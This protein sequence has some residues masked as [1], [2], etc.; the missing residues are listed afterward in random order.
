MEGRARTA[1]VVT[2]QSSDPIRLARTFLLVALALCSTAVARAQ[3]PADEP[4]TTREIYVPVSDL[5]VLLESGP[6][7]VLL[8][9][10]EYD[11]LVKKAK[12]TPEKHVPHPTVTVSSDYDVT[13]DDGRAKLHGTIAIDVL[14]DGLQA[15][16]LDFGYVG[17]LSAKLDEQPAPIGFAPD[18]RL[19]LL[20]SGQGRHQLVLDM[21]APLEMDSA[22]QYLRFR[23]TNAAVGRWRLTAPGDVEIKG[24]AN[25]VSR[26]VDEAAKLTRFELL[27]CRGDSTI[28]MSL[29]SH[30]QRR[31]QAVAS[32]CVLFDEVAEAYE[33]L[34]AT[35]TLWVLHR[36]VDR[37]RFVV[38]D[39]FEIAE[40]DSPLLARWDVETE[41][42]RKIVNV[43]LREQTTDTVVL[44]IAAVKTPSQ[45]KAW[46]MPRLEMLD[47]VGQVTVLGLLV[48]DQL[49]AESLVTGDLIPVDTGVLAT[50][51]PA[52][53]VRTEP[54]AVVLRYIAAYYA[55]QSGYEL[56]ADFS[57]TPATLAVTT[58]LL[59]K[60]QEKGCEVQG[61]FALLP[62]AERRFS[63]DF[64][65][66]AGWTVLE[67][68]GPDHKPLGIERHAG[69]KLP[70]PA[71]RGAG[72]EGNAAPNIPHPNPVPGGGGTGGRVHVKLPQG[73]APDQV[74]MAGFRAQYTPPGWLGPWKNQ[75]LAL[76]LFRVADAQREE[77]AVGVAAEEDMEVK[78]DNLERL[79]PITGAEMG[80]YG[81]AAGAMNLAYRYEGAGSKATIAVDR[82]ESRATARSFAFFQVR[83]DVLK[84]HYVV[85][86][87]IAGAKTRRLALLLPDS[88]PLSL[89]IRGLEG[90]TVE[91]TPE[92]A[93]ALRHAGP[94]AP[95]DERG[96]RPIRE[97]P[98]AMRR[99]NVL[100][101][102]ARRGEVRLA[103]D[104]EMRP[105]AAARLPSP[106]GGGAEG[107][108]NLLPS[109]SG[110]GAGGEG[111]LLPSPSGRGAGGEGGLQSSTTKTNVAPTTPYPSP[112][113]E[114]E[115]DQTTG[116]V[117]ELKDFALPMLTADGVVYQSGMVA[118]EGDLELGVE[119][120]KTDARRA[121]VGQLAIARYALASV[122]PNQQQAG[123]RQSPMRLVGAYEFLGDPPRVP[124]DVVRNSSYALTPAIVQ[125]AKLATL[126]SADGTSQTKAAF[127]IRTKASYLEVEL[128]G[129]AAL[130]SAVLDGT[131]LK[132]QTQNGIRLIG[133]PPSPTGAA[134]SLQLVYEA[135]VQSL[136]TG[137]RMDLVAPRLLYR[138]SRTATQSTEIP[139]V[140]IEWTVTVPDG[141][142]AVATDGTLE[143]KATERPVPAPLVVAGT[144]YELGGGFLTSAR[145]AGRRRAA[146]SDLRQLGI[147]VHGYMTQDNMT[148][149]VQ[150]NSPL[151]G[152]GVV[153][154]DSKSMQ[155]RDA[156]ARGGPPGFPVPSLHSPSRRSAAQYDAANTPQGS[157]YPGAVDE[158]APR[159][160]A[161]ESAYA[162]AVPQLGGFD[163]R[164]KDMP[165]PPP[166]GP[167]GPGSPAPAIDESAERKAKPVDILESAA[168]EA[169]PVDKGWR[170]ERGEGHT[171]DAAN[172][173]I[174]RQE[175]LS[176]F[177][178]LKI[179]LQ[180]A[181]VDERQRLTFSSLGADPRIGI[182]LARRN[183]N[184]VLVW[185]LALAAFVLGVAMT[186]RPA[187]EKI[188]LVLGL[189]LASALL[190]LVWD[191]VSFARICNGVF[192][193]ASLLVPY[194]LAA[195]LVRWVFCR[196]RGLVGR[197]AGPPAGPA[198]VTA[199]LVLAMALLLS[200]TAQAQPQP[201]NGQGLATEREEPVIVPGDAIIVP[202]D[203]KSEAGV[204]D[205]DHLLLP[206]DRYVELWNRAHPDKK[207]DAHP[208]PL[209]YALSGATYRAVLEGQETLNVAGQMQIDVLTDGYVSVPLDFR[210]GVL[211]RADLDGKPAQLN[212]GAGTGPGGVTK[213]GKPAAA[214]DATLL[215]LQVSG[216]G[217][218]KLE[219]ELRLKVGKQGGWRGTTGWLPIAPAATVTFRVPQPQTEV[220]LGQVVDRDS[221]ARAGQ[222]V[223][224]RVLETQQPDEIVETALGPDGILQVQWRP[225]V[226]EAEVDRGLTVQTAGL[227][228]VEEDGLRLALQVNLEFPRSQRDAF[229][230]ALPL[231][232]LVEKVAGSNV[233]GWEVRR[234]ADRQTVE[235]S[236]LKT[237]KE[238][239]KFNLFLSRSGKVGQAPL[240]TFAVPMVTVSD[241]ALS[242]GQLTIRRSS[243]LD[244]RTTE[245]SGV[246]RTDLGPPVDLSGGPA[247]EESVLAVRPY[248]AYR[249]PTTP[250]TLRLSAAPTVAEVTAEAQTSVKL[251]PTEPGL[252]SKIIFHV[253]Q[254][255]TYRFE[256]AVPDDFRL[257]EV[258]LPSSG[259]WSIEKEG[260]GNSPPLP[261]GEGR[262]EGRSVL[263]V[264]FQQGVL[265]DAAVIVR[266]KLA[267]LD[268]RQELA[269]PRLE[270]LG[271]KRQEGL[272]AI[273]ADPAFNVQARDLR[274]C[275]ET[276]LERVAAWLDPQLRTLTRLALHYTGGAYAGKLRLTPRTP[277][278]VCETV[279]NV[280][281]TDR[282]I[283]ETIILNYGI[284]NAGIHELTFLLPASMA[285]ARISTPLLQRKTMVRADPKAAD[286]PWRVHVEL[287]SDVMNDLRV[288]VE[289]DRLL[290]P[291][292]EKGP[293]VAPLPILEA[294]AGRG[295]DSV[296]RQYVVLES[297]NRDELV[298]K[299]EGLQA[300]SRQQQEW[301]TLSELLGGNPWHKAYFV[302][303]GA[304]RPQLGFYL[305]RHADVETAGA[306]I[307]LAQTTLVVDAN[308]AYRAQ[309]ELR[310]DNSS[311]QFLDV[312][313]PKGATLWTVHVA[314][315]PV[316]PA[317]APGPLSAGPG[318]A[319]HVLLP[320]R[321]TAKGDP[322]YL[323]VLKYGGQM[324]PF[325][326]LSTVQFPL[327]L[328][329]K[330]PAGRAIGIEQTQVEI[331]VPKSHQWF[332]FRGTMHRA[333]EADLKAGQLAAL[334]K[335]GEQYI[336]ATHDKDAFARLRA[337]ENLKNWVAEAQ[338]SVDKAGS[339]DN[340]AL[341][342]QIAANSSLTRVANDVLKSSTGAMTISAGTLQVGNAQRLNELYRK[343]GNVIN[344][345]VL[346]VAGPNSY[347]GGTTISGGTLQVGNANSLGSGVLTASS[348]VVLTD[349]GNAAD[350]NGNWIRRNNFR[351]P[352]I[353][354]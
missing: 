1:F 132:P 320:V 78:A 199:A 324:P 149:S 133:L 18:G 316:K 135:P 264:H 53:L 310:L 345:G 354:P 116:K 124:V 144:L 204:K 219:L 43:R 126:L 314:G 4:T 147:A 143:V 153:L 244:L 193:A 344:G 77:G 122:G 15:V 12:Q 340:P 95:P 138:A 304:A 198:S 155:G 253:G 259:V 337:T 230:L 220:R 27:P 68:T 297:E 56:K 206:Y 136:T 240:D 94:A 90:A 137:K 121:D 112:L 185:G 19:N 25:V 93:G 141:Y 332:D 268:A 89:T 227:L 97:P 47:V 66:P 74:Y 60:I 203:V 269:L 164:A 267:P 59:L 139:L 125:Q 286:S 209:P 152:W 223:D 64:S 33:K 280:R 289:D 28:R 34:H 276:E 303:P 129:K 307:D 145:E 170:H 161:A 157:T 17:L 92:T 218:H 114:G 109:P 99:W 192:Y 9:R 117:I 296:R 23:L 235:V 111:N 160:S 96:V 328:N 75:S 221:E 315:E 41:A 57:R 326:V 224:R 271:V 215:V 278:V 295:A 150:D 319:S 61:G 239:E 31:E 261:P 113:P 79:V 302:Q 123:P 115:G 40:I 251:D 100:L 208:A 86:Y 104:F 168:R 190:P 279:T 228:D 30:L 222:A 336:E 300:V 105:Q 42:G 110:R 284:R 142:E 207:I 342:S 277:E 16:P 291:G 254:R 85:I 247:T 305:Q 24:G 175:N 35:V 184:T 325:S 188:A 232:Y 321:K 165:P 98:A 11:E 167:A 216:K 186:A 73:I 119:V 272:V 10:Q 106:S 233:R 308:G 146:E 120:Q 80:R 88:T 37:F 287:Q 72:G 55:P 194:Y 101:D 317:Q 71:G 312:E 2:R 256:V 70:S 226:A 249:F 313:L 44:S 51:L 327:V 298:E 195:G 293:H 246:T 329:V 62:T 237:A 270:V 156:E 331:Y 118:I 191:T 107:E 210:G 225:K 341:K 174:Y 84:A 63:F 36:A 22:Q 176:G 162:I 52:T 177:R 351:T 347:S 283:E 87:S 172:G 158:K 262:G 67:V 309:V 151:G 205:A 214:M 231:E 212:V 39:G 48:E 330:S 83:P 180:P 236:L 202:Y 335:Q 334:A 343:Q 350:F 338:Q 181:G 323:V 265:G 166:S 274:D 45:L 243:L 69:E 201:A 211:A 333:E 229:T 127:Q 242:S 234:A 349:N 8:T 102:Q 81:L 294:V 171:D 5:K 189:A 241:A 76:P 258:T 299:P 13:V 29:N 353:A 26:T 311:E 301:H 173:M 154:D 252:E 169:K 32:R 200:A 108:G 197:M 50:A 130:W 348:G 159:P 183:R 346:Q 91:F 263:K 6:H 275:Q 163:A 257:P 179:D 103:V 318:N 134:R 288:L 273:E 131:P 282:A 322:N 140:H 245:K 255:R 250:F 178:S 82:T 7:R 281:V 238:T 54:G 196:L 187:R 306:R 38:P 266:G 128:P 352:D 248:E 213:G 3:T 260:P 339:A 285:D 148:S 290:T 58:N 292:S 65:V 46:R 20:V 21:V 182:T 217:T 49:K 14:G